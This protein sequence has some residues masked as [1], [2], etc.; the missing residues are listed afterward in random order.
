MTTYYDWR[1]QTS[2]ATGEDWRVKYFLIQSV[3]MDARVCVLL[4][5]YNDFKK[6]TYCWSNEN[7][8]RSVAPQIK[9]S[10]NLYLCAVWHTWS[11]HSECTL[12][13]RIHSQHT[14]A[15]IKLKLKNWLIILFTERKLQFAGCI[16]NC[17]PFSLVRSPLYTI[18]VL[19]WLRFAHILLLYYL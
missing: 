2:A 4:A 19:Y 18:R 1:A 6:C 12:H 8:L 16:A 5:V 14:G 13:A 10:R 17:D 11:I 3:L 15:A 7:P 9:Y